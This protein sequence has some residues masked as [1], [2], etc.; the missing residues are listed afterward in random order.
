MKNKTLHIGVDGAFIRSF[1]DFI[2]EDFD[3]NNHYFLIATDS[4][5]CSKSGN[6][7][8]YPRTILSRL[9][10]YI[11]AVVRMHQA[12]KIILHGLFDNKLI[13]L[14]FLMPWI[15]KKT[16]WVL[17]GG[18]LYSYSLGT[19]NWRWKIAEFF[20]RPVIKNIKLITTTVPG[21]YELAKSWYGFKGTFIPNLMYKSHVYREL[22]NIKRNE[23]K[24]DDIYVQVGNSSDPS[25]NHIEILSYLAK[26][27]DLP[28][29]VFCPLSYG[30]D[31]H[32]DIV[33]KKGK[34][35]LGNKFIPITKLMSFDDY[36]N[37]MSSI[38]IAIFNHDRQQAM[39]NII[40]L[41]SLGKKV[42]MKNS[43]TPYKFFSDLGIKI[44][45]LE[46]KELFHPIEDMLAQAN[47]KAAKSFFTLE[48]LKK[49]WKEV[50]DA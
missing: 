7:K 20:R 14:L 31:E 46:D 32:R 44:Y 21:D 6:V 15:L 33:V 19:Q 38:D 50:F 29:K 8:F 42:V 36:N 2:K 43:I 35:L 13:F 3:F 22:D 16:C 27:I 47:I 23:K 10:Y 9:R 37:Y 48:Q 25:N 39:G 40:G 41:I 49:N 26:E 11:N 24:D 4:R 28:I 18:D 34:E 12:R 5:D 17:W 45:T 1:V 30:S